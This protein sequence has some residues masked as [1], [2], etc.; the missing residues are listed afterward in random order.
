MAYTPNIFDAGVD[1]D[2]DEHDSM[3]CIYGQR[4]EGEE[5]VMVVVKENWPGGETATIDC[6]SEEAAQKMIDAI[7]EHADRAMVH[8]VFN[9]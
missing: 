2:L 3:T 7:G 4:M 1:P 5:V 6:D 8:L 9:T